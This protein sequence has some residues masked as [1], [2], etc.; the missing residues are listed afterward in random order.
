MAIIYTYPEKNVLDGKEK[1]LI[2]D[3]N[4]N[5]K[6]KNVTLSS[7]KTGLN[8]VESILAGNGISVSGTNDI[9][10]TNTGVLS[11]NSANSAIVASASTGAID[12]TSTVY[13]GGSV[14]GHVPTGGSNSTFLRGDGTWAPATGT[15][16]N[17]AGSN[18]E[19]QYNDNSSFGAT[20][21]LTYS[22]DTLTV[23]DNIVIKGDGSADA[24]KLRLNCFNNNHYVDIIGPNHAGSPIS[25]SLTLPQNISTSSPVG[26]AGRILE[27]NASGILQWISTPTDTTY[28]AG[29]GLSLATNTFS[30]A[31]GAALT[32]LGGGTGTTYLKKDGTW[33]TPASGGIS[34]NGSTANGIATYSSATQANV[35]STFTISG[36]R[37]DAPI[38]SAAT[39]SITFG[40]ANNGISSYQGGI[41]LSAG[42]NLKFTAG[43]AL[44]INSQLTQF[45]SGLKFTSSG[46]AMDSYE[47]GT[48]TPAPYV[49]TGT[50]PG[51]TGASGVYTK[52]GDMV[53]ITF[54]MTITSYSSANVFM[55]I[56][57]LPFNGVNT[58]AGTRGIISFWSNG[59]DYI[60][61][62]PISAMVNYTYITPYRFTSSTDFALTQC[63]WYAQA[64]FNN[65]T[66]TGGGCYKA[67]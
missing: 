38:G 66:L 26:A 42:G 41:Q 65:Y 59:G 4:D 46:T 67:V 33:D 20:P 1:F 5:G 25:Y 12:I 15:A 16:A 53:Y 9:T 28:S 55:A 7:L 39:P 21:N 44:N 49:V 29:T 18:T 11:L 2:S 17:P 36:N 34:F 60:Q 43:T 14:I 32:N 10:V 23:Q 31:T 58:N 48:W 50:A 62:Q 51:V 45:D 40:A 8:V 19:L 54:T 6:T 47:E 24:G 37:L 13:G 57:G 22:A 27:S 61:Q 52:I 30:L 56:Q 63:S 64:A 35:S 3:D